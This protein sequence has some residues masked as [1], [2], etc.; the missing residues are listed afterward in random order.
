MTI[1]GYIE[2]A[3]SVIILLLVIV[4]LWFWRLKDNAAKDLLA[5]QNT[6]ITDVAIHKEDAATIV[7][8]TAFR[9]ADDTIIL[10]FSNEVEAINNHFNGIENAISNL[11]R[12]NADVEKY[13][14]QPIPI[15][16]RNVLN[17]VPDSKA[18]ASN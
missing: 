18:A 8:I 17:G 12:T 3:L 14:S 9:K 11:R 1:R 5:A 10:K 7:H 2:I 4:A 16:L 6:H 15:A 13:L